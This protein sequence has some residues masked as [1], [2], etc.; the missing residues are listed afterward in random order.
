MH[1]GLPAPLLDITRV[2]AGYGSFTVLRDVSISIRPGTVFGIIGPNGH[3]K[4]TLM[5]AISGFVRLSKGSIRL[6]GQRIDGLPPHRIAASGVAHIPQGDLVFPDLSVF[7]NLSMGAY[8]ERSAARQRERLDYVYSIFP[9]LG[10]RSNQC[11]SSLSG[12]ERRMLAIGR[13]LMGDSRLLLVDEPSL[14]LAPIIIE[15]IYEVLR[16][17]KKKRPDDSGGGGKS[18][19]PH[20]PGR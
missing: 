8:L 7:E 19:P 3:G 1:S 11:A 15:Q 20:R 13:G 14:G 18:C 10:Q 5:N 2:S 9:K 12:G 4:T 16:V 6:G 17:L